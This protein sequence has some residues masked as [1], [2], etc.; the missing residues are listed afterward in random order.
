MK[1]LLSFFLFVLLAHNVVAQIQVRKIQPAGSNDKK[2][3]KKINNLMGTS[4]GSKEDSVEQI[5]PYKN[6]DG[7]TTDVTLYYPV[8]KSKKAYILKDYFHEKAG[9]MVRYKFY[10]I[11]LDKKGQYIPN[12]VFQSYKGNYGFIKHAKG[13]GQHLD[14]IWI[15]P[16][17]SQM[18]VDAAKR[19][20]DFS[21]QVG[22][23]AGEFTIKDMTG[24]EYVLSSL[25]GKVVVLKFWFINC[26]PCVKE[27]P[28]LNALK[29]E[30]GSRNDIVF[31]A[32]ALDE[33]AALKKFLQQKAFGFAVAPAARKL[34]DHFKVEYYPTHVIIDKAGVIRY[35]SNNYTEKSVSELKAAI[36]KLL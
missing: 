9:K 3:E 27:I 14:T 15:T 20:S 2:E 25:K 28:E 30:L 13:R 33:S 5:L 4:D 22:K 6:P 29:E 7:T 24:K 18:I 21:K 12:E 10:N 34:V 23:P 16:P 1:K 26:A 17:T 11:Y 31:L 19:K 8:D 36:L 35:L 32:P